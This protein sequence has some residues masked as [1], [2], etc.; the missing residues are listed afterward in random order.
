MN[1][2]T[3]RYELSMCLDGRLPSG[4]RSVVLQHAAECVGCR[5]FW[6]ELQQ[7]QQ[8]ALQLPKHRV[9]AGFHT[10]LW[11][12][13]RAGE[14]TPEAV[15]HE[16]IPW[17][18]KAR[19]VMTGA[20]AAA[21]V[22]AL[23]LVLRPAN[24]GNSNQGNS[25]QEPQPQTIAAADPTSSSGETR[26]GEA[27]SGP[28][29]ED[30]TRPSATRRFS[31]S[32]SGSVSSNPLAENGRATMANAGNGMNAP[33]AMLASAQ[34][35][36]ANAVAVEAARQFEQRFTQASQRMKH[37]PQE[38][39]IR[40][41]LDDANEL[42]LLAEVLLDLRDHDRVSFRDAEVGADLRLVANL[43]GQSRLQK[44]SL[45]TVR[46]CVAPA[47]QQGERLLQLP[48]LIRLRPSFDDYEQY[49]ELELLRRLSTQR[50]EVLPK[51]FYIFPGEQHTVLPG[52][53]VRGDVLVFE[54]QCGPALVAPRS[55]V[56]EGNLRFQFL[57]VQLG[58]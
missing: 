47:L 3:C 56:E 45:E 7:A 10:Q 52:S 20:A 48:R 44:S 13:I 51:L 54:D 42:H 22:L 35:L 17:L 27:L 33:P 14:G 30:Q 50:P 31:G 11:E 37:L 40:A 57:R 36:T 24:Q 16:P 8:L 46:S 26:N 39:V 18:T 32:V 2:N 55:R 19:Y 1:C 12:R 43:L 21:A 38:Q 49:A 4:R 9:S 25:N 53:I 6:A 28:A 5:R 41:V 58:R 29:T 34:P 15:F 23:A